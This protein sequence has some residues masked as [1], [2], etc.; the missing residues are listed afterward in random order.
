MAKNDFTRLFDIFHYQQAQHPVDVALAYKVNG[1]WKKYSTDEVVNI[2]NKLSLGFYKLG[3]Q[4]GDKIAIASS[5][6]RP[7]WNFCDHAM[8]QCGAINVPVYPTISENEYQYIFNHAEVKYAFAGDEKLAIKLRHTQANTPSLKEVYTFDKVPGF[9]HWTEILDLAD[10]KDMPEIE[11]IKASINPMD[12]A[13]LVYTSG[14]TGTPKGVMLSHNNIISNIK[15]GYTVLPVQSGNVVISFL[16]LCHIFERMVTY[17]YFSIG[18]KVYYAESIDTIGD[19]IREVK[20]DIFTAVPRLLE[21]VYD[22][23]INKGLELTG[24]KRKLFFWAVDLGLKWD[25]K[26]HGLLYNQQLKLANKLIFS[27]WREAL[28]GNIKAIVSGSAPLQTRLIRVFN[29]ANIKVREGYGLTE[30]SPALFFSSLDENG[31]KVGYVGKLLK[32]VECK[33]AP[34]GEIL[35]KGP[36]IMMGYYKEP[37]KTAEVLSPDGWF[38]T[39]D[40]GEI[41]ADGFLR[42]TDRK[43]ELL[44]TSGGKYVA[45]APIENKFKESPLIE[46]I[47]VL[48]ES[49]RFVSALIVPAFP[50]LLDWCKSNDIASDNIKEVISNPRVQDQYQQI[51]DEFNP[52]FNH[53]EQIKKFVILPNEW[54]VDSGELAPTMKLKRKVILEKYKAEI[55]KIYE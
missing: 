30:T 12:L 43:K 18:A 26:D 36:N 31:F 1:E 45:P 50:N 8:M 28:G 38:S 52:S 4:K 6:N 22:R 10:E 20:P 44:K 54:T 27:K 9:K 13:T 35:V 25:N 11:K 46:Q 7:E 34:D 40:I 2:I 23:I 21:K 16:P 24:F 42:I 5:N 37:E 47:I 48:G 55:Q 39:G 15:S 49:Q 53:I 32:D 51:I 17:V 41:D 19:N 33:L 3:L 29:A 14:T